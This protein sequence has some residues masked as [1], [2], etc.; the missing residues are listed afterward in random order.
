MVKIDISRLIEN[1][2]IFTFHGKDTD[3]SLCRLRCQP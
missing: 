2:F 3:I 1:L